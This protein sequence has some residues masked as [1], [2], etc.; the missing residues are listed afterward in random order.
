MEETKKVEEKE[1]NKI[2]AKQAFSKRITKYLG[3]LSDKITNVM[4]TPA[5]VTVIITAILGPIAI[6]W[7]NSDMENK[8]LQKQVITEILKYT[9][10][11][12]FSKT[13]SI[14]KIGIIATMVDENRNVFGL[15]FSTTDSAFKDLYKVRSEYGISNLTKE[16][17]EN[18]KN[19]NSLK[20]KLS[21]DSASIKDLDLKKIELES[22]LEKVKQDRKL[23]REDR[24]KREDKL[25][26]EIE[27]KELSISGLKQAQSNYEK[28]IEF[29]N[30][31]KKALDKNLES[32][33]KNL[34]N[35]LEE[36][37][38]NQEDLKKYK[39]LVT[40]KEN[41]A[42]KLSDALKT[43]TEKHDK[44]LNDIESFKQQLKRLTDENKKLKK[45]KNA[46]NN[47]NK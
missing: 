24:K 7:V 30:N 22:E 41:D 46:A 14:E 40:K 13:E 12:D 36:N 45:E 17:D 19:I 6:N 39:D 25:K 23:S 32:A 34:E 43:L 18:K 38:K 16:L 35:A 1:V 29:W 27:K 33:T 44:S 21:T 2:E 5:V 28:Q 15:S 3:N 11:A 20:S 31:Q 42:V 10:G 8:Q 37:K 47:N 4:F 26:N 9:N